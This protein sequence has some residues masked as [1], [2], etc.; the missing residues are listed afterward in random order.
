MPISNFDAFRLLKQGRSVI[1]ECGRCGDSIW[2]RDSNYYHGE[3]EWYCD[4]CDDELTEAVLEEMA[5][6]LL[7]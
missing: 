6:D 4:E 3:D 2:T 5:D 7:G 1:V